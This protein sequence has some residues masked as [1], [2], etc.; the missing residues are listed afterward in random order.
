MPLAD[1]PGTATSQPRPP[2]RL[3]FVGDICLSLSTGRMLKALTRG[4]PVPKSV[5]PGFPFRGVAQR[6]KS[7]DLAM[8]NLECV[9]SLQG[10][11]NRRLPFRAPMESLGALLQAGIDVVGVANNH[12]LDCGEA[13]F[14]H[15]VKNLA[16]KNIGVVGAEGFGPK[17]QVPTVQQVRDLRIG[18][19][20]YP[21]VRPAKAYADVKAARND[22][23]LLVIY[24]HWGMEGCPSPTGFQR[25]LAQGLIDAGADL[26][27]G[28]HAHVIQPEQWYQGKYIFYGLGDFVFAG[29][30]GE[31]KRTGGFLE[32]D[33][34]R[35][36]VLARRFY[37]VRFGQWGAPEW[38]DS[39]P[40]KPPQ[41][42]D[43]ANQICQPRPV[44]T[45]MPKASAAP[46]APS[47]PNSD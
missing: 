20:A 2:V 42:G 28:T 5:Q 46:K 31:P 3:A 37:R 11:S 26:V 34:A 22:V 40:V 23:D 39:A 27:L 30:P 4:W 36:Q 38:I 13:G 32:V 45:A 44:Y 29:N 24:L 16:E 33:V 21:H 41:L 35:H 6:L 1:A 18:F 17:R 19:L 14:R 7:A 8:G 47:A 15:M 25:E 12:A 43:A 10:Q 9:I